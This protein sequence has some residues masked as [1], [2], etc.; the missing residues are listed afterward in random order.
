MSEGPPSAG[1]SERRTPV[2]RLH[3][4]PTLGS[5]KKQHG[6]RRASEMYFRE[7]EYLAPPRST[8]STPPPGRKRSASLPHVRSPSPVPPPLS[9][10]GARE[11]DIPKEESTMSKLQE[12]EGEQ[13]T[14]RRTRCRRGRPSL[15][16]SSCSGHITL[17]SHLDS[18]IARRRHSV[19][20]KVAPRDSWLQ[21]E[22]SSEEDLA[23]AVD[24][25]NLRGG[26]ASGGK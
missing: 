10:R 9:R 22:T 14:D 6:Q 8:V 11:E 26:T 7:P 16:L 3:G 13:R 1:P 2:I 24:K 12:E 4:A 21:E 23:N 17:G 5:P 18:E 25:L 20:G 19:A 15:D